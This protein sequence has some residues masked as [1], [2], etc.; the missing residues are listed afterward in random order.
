MYNTVHQID[1][2]KESIYCP[3][4]YCI[5]NETFLLFV[6]VLSTITCS[7]FFLPKIYF[8]LHTCLL[9]IKT[10]SASIFLLGFI[11]IEAG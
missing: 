1:E 6:V 10:K 5:Y 7:L 11:N 3:N 2:R 9:I 4:N 8:T